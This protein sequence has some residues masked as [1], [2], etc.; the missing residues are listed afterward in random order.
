MSHCPNSID[1][2]AEPTVLGWLD[3]ADFC[4]AR[5]EC[6]G[7]ARWRNY[8][9]FVIERDSVF[10]G[11]GMAGVVAQ[12]QR[13][14]FDSF[15]SWSRLTGAATDLDGLD[16]FAAHWRWRAGHSLNAVVGHLGDPGDPD[17]DVASTAGAQIVRILPDVFRRQQLEF[18]KLSLLPAPAL[19]VYATLVVECCLPCVKRAR[20]PSVSFA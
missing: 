16:V 12:R 3:R 2:A 17:D 9:E 19:N 7:F 8:R 4:R 11:F 18:E 15:L 20:R 14:P 6:R 5:R 10:L 1:A 13:V